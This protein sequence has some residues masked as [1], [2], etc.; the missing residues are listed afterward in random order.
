[1]FLLNVLVHM[2]NLLVQ[3]LLLKAGI[4]IPVTELPYRR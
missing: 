4:D 1:M 3:V 2:R